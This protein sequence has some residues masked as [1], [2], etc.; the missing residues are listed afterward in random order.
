MT[1]EANGM[2]G[3]LFGFLSTNIAAQK[4]NLVNAAYQ[5]SE[6]MTAPQE[7]DDEFQEEERPA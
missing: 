3:S 2:V 1:P 4:T 7:E 6:I 5:A